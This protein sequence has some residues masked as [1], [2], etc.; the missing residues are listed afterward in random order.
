MKDVYNPN[1]GLRSANAAYA[2]PWGTTTAPTVI[3]E[4]SNV[5]V[6]SIFWIIS[7][8]TCNKVSKEPLSI[9]TANPMCEW[10]YIVAIPFQSFTCRKNL[11]QPLK[12]VWFF[13][14]VCVCA[15]D[16]KYRFAPRDAFIY[17]HGITIVEFDAQD[18]GKA[19][20][21]FRRNW[22]RHGRLRCFSG[23]SVVKKLT[24]RPTRLISLESLRTSKSRNEG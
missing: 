3:P 10:K 17:T 21:N 20:T 11:S 2:M 4:K 7:R 13:L 19:M 24:R 15:R 16:R 1:W 6:D 22:S 23:K 14:Y 18:L 9:V 12:N 5:S 8:L